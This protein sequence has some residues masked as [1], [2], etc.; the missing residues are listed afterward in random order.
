M[1][2]PVVLLIALLAIS[3]LP[4]S[5][6]PA[7]AQI[8]G[9]PPPAAQTQPQTTLPNPDL[10]PRPTRKEDVILYNRDEQKLIGR[11]TLPDD[12][13]AVLEQPQ[14]REWRQFR[15]GL[16]RWVIGGA[17]LAMA[18]ILA[19]FFLWRG[20]IRID[21]GRSG[22]WVPRFSSL[23]RTTHWLTSV[24]FLVLAVTGLA[25]TFGRPLLIPLIGHE[26]FTTTAE[27]AKLAHNFSAFPFMAGLLLMIGLWLRDNVPA[28][29][30]LDWI[31]NAGGLLKSTS[32]HPLSETG[33]FNAGQKGVFWMVVLGGGAMSATGLLL[34]LPFSVTGIAGMQLMHVAHAIL[35]G[36]MMAAILAHTYIGSIGMEGAFDAMGRG[37][38]DENWAIEHHRGWYEAEKRRV[39]EP[40][41]SQT[42]G[43]D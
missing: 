26:A 5:A 25:V 10:G 33:R 43:A 32:T 11:I 17:M 14:G 31:R 34:M 27:F 30:D 20:T 2:R 28:R 24:S 12:K 39:P 37:A 1:V 16:S 9:A 22:R 4:G 21:R 40:A 38:V 18:A 36:L 23:E 7:W 35:G 29:A 19:I 41:A 6:R 42:A 3:V 15:T 8:E 13:L